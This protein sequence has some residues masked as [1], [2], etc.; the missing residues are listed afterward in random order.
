[1]ECS[2]SRQSILDHIT[3]QIA[4][5]AADAIWYG[6]NQL[7]TIWAQTADNARSAA[8]RFV[9]GGFSDKHYGLSRFWVPERI[10]EIDLEAMDILH[11]CY[12]RAKKILERNRSLMDRIVDLLVEKKSLTK[13]EFFQLVEEYGQ[14]EPYP[15]SIVDIRAAK[16]VQFHELMSQK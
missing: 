3:V 9:L 2:D 13:Q 5:R 6:E 14:L 4:P 8:R 11:K 12:D 1:M 10:D 16:R 15:P 7:S